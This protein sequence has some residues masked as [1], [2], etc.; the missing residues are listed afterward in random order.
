VACAS[1][2]GDL[3]VDPFS[4]SASTGAACLNLGRR[5]LGIERSEAFAEQSRKRLLAHQVPAAP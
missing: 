1:D 2:P 4:G 3:V 5:Y